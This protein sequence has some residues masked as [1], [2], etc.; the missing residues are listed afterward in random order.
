MTTAAAAPTGAAG[1]AGTSALRGVARSG[2]VSTVGSL[3]TSLL[4]FLVVVQVSRGLGAEGVGAFSVAVA[5]A[6]VLGVAGRLGTDTAM[7]RTVPRLRELGR[8]ADIRIAVR[9]AVVPV[10]VVTTG[11]AG[12]LWLLAPWV[13]PP[14]FGEIPVAESVALM[15]VAALTV[16]LAAACYVALQAISGLGTIVPLTVVESITKPAARC[17]FIAIALFAGAGVFGVTVAWALPVLL[18]AVMA[19]WMLRRRLRGLSLVDA[20]QPDPVATRREVWRFAGPRGVAA[21]FEVAGLHV[22]VVLLSALAGAAAAGVYSSV[23][24]LALVGMLGLQALRLAVA[25]QI[26]RMLTE[27]DV[28]GVERVHRA[29]T[30]WVVLV[31][32]PVFLILLS[33]PS[34]VL[35]LFGPEFQAGTVALSVLAAAMLLNVATGNVATVLLMSGRSSITLAVTVLSLG[36]GVLLTVLLGPLYGVLGA[37]IAKAIS[38]VFENVVVTVAVRRTV[39]VRT[40]SRPLALAVTAGIAC[41]AVP[42]AVL[43]AVGAVGAGT[44]GIPLAVGTVLVAS[45]AYVV[46]AW[47]A[48][49]QYELSAL[50]SVLPARFTRRLRGAS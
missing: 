27:G 3:A 48:R 13:A 4:G 35:T 26:S 7:V 34:Q 2:A 23:L 44:N 18:G 39:G 45:A 46:L 19:G 28:A 31:S 32:F 12:L 5:I 16:P 10:G 9:A 8:Q 37:A 25:P 6:M 22:G 14:L 33:W 30:V 24:R 21:V 40:L 15:R 1:P 29:S 42:A 43:H 41:Y 20:A 49:N 11:L 36:I 17:L 50:A 38:T 47:R